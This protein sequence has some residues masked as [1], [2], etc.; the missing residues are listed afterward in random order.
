M[1][2]IQLDHRWSDGSALSILVGDDTR[3]G[4]PDQLAELQARAIAIHDRLV[5]SSR[6]RST[7]VNHDEP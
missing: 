7:N 2:Y 3:A 5:P 6:P 1:A 4:Y